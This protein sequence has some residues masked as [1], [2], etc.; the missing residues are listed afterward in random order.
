MVVFLMEE[1]L[2]TELDAVFDNRLVRIAAGGIVAED[3]LEFFFLLLE[4]AQNIGD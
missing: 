2:V 1:Q 3:S 4:A